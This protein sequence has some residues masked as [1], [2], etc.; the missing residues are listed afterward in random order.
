MKNTIV[1]IMS[2][3][4]IIVSVADISAQRRRDM[5]PNF[6]R[7][8]EQLN[9]TDQQKAKLD[10]LRMQH[11]EKM[12][13]MRADLDKARI[14]N[15]RLR[16]SDKLNRGDVINQTKTMSDIRNKMAEARANHMMDVYETLTVEQRKIWNDLKMDRP[17][18]KDGRNKRNFDRGFRGRCNR[19]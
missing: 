11:Q 15:Q 7:I 2:V 6:D 3:L 16:R 12:I 18:F 9:L 8:H 5:R 10:D 14:E 1:I 17:G 19:F 13:D 4:I